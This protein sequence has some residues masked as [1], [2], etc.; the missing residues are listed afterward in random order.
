MPLTKCG[1]PLA[2]KA[3]AAKYAQY[4]KGI[5]FEVMICVSKSRI[6]RRIITALAV[7]I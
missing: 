1:I 3:P 4:S 5:S 7:L 2:R 6:Q